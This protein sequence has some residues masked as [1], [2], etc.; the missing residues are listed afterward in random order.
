MVRSDLSERNCSCS[1]V[2]LS[3]TERSLT[4]AGIRYNLDAFM[5]R[6]KREEVLLNCATAFFPEFIDC[7]LKTIL[8]CPPEGIMR[9]NGKRMLK[10]VLIKKF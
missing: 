8:F 9:I 3:A 5:K 4:T 10:T 1:M 6:I 7:A 2:S